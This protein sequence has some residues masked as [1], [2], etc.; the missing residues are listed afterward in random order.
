[1]T[2]QTT[3][4]PT[5]ELTPLAE[6]LA[7]VLKK[8]RPLPPIDMDLTQS[9]GNVLAEEVR[10]PTALP[11]FDHASIDGYAARSEDI[12]G[13]AAHRPVRLNVVGD[14]SAASW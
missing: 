7:G 2:A 3:L 12:M 5:P 11:A 8:L 6:F 9:Y 10:A 4:A 1:M 14:L 13:A